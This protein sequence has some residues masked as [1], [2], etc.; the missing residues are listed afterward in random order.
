M[1]NVKE[2]KMVIGD[3]VETYKR[4]RTEINYYFL[5]KFVD[6]ISKKTY[7]SLFVSEISKVVVDFF[8]RLYNVPDF[9][10]STFNSLKSYLDYYYSIQPEETLQYKMSNKPHNYAYQMVDKFLNLMYENKLPT[11]VISLDVESDGLWGNPISI[12][13]TIEED[14]KVVYKNEA[15]CLSNLDNSS[16]WVKENVINP[17]RN[18]KDIPKFETYRE[19]LSWFANEYMKYKDTH[20]VIYHMGH[21]VESN[22]FKELISY[23]LIGEWDAPYTPVE[24]STLLSVRGFAPDSVDALVKEGL[25]S[26]PK[27]S[28]VHQALYDAEVAGKA[29]WYLKNIIQK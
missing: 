17:L 13:F 21:I 6:E 20:T 24:I 26:A 8:K 15:C 12:G 4:E 23:R 10:G 2:F 28:Q 9:Q 27:E 22:L 5:A 29:Y 18:R 3:F 1:K 25:I 14:G 19:L 7:A 16:D 11:R